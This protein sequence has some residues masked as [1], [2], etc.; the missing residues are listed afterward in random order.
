M[1]GLIKISEKK[2]W[3]IIKNKLIKSVNF[4]SNKQKFFKN[5]KNIN[6]KNNLNQFLIK[7]YY[8]ILKIKTYLIIFYTIILL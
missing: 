8:K 5:V 7:Y 6:T 2:K 4:Q 3:K 1:R